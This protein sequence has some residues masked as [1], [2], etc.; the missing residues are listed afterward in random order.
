MR[1]KRHIWPR[2][3]DPDEAPIFGQKE[4]GTQLAFRE[5]DVRLGMKR[6]LDFCRIIRGRQLQDGIDWVESL[7]RM[8]S[9]V[10]LKLMNQAKEECIEKYKMDPARVYIF[11]AQPQRGPFVRQLKKHARANF[12]IVRSPR[13]ILMIRVRQLPLEE[14]FHRM[15][16]NNKVPRSVASDMRLALHQN[17]V[18]P[19]MQKEWG[20][21]VCANS[22]FWHRKQLKWLDSTRQFDYYQARHEW[23][24]R[25]RANLVRGSVEARE[26]RGLPPMPAA[27]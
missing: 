17:R 21:Y 9:G 14:Y 2:R 18:N 22:R 19:Q 27:D 8:K 1:K 23:I 20:P 10:V 11:D 16:I 7:A 24:Q 6:L 25:Y 12:G 3:H 15:Y 5:R 4:D 13:N 26:A